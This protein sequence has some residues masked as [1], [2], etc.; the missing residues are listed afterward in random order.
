[1]YSSST[2]FNVGVPGEVIYD[3]IYLLGFED[4]YFYPHNRSLVQSIRTLHDSTT[5]VYFNYEFN[6]NNQL[7]KVIINFRE[8]TNTFLVYDYEYY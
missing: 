8:P 6:S 4:Y 3:F 7:T 5:I 1:M 2:L